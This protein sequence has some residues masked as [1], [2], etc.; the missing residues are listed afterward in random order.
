MGWEQQNASRELT[1]HINSLCST[2]HALAHSLTHLPTDSPTHSPTHSPTYRSQSRPLYQ[3]QIGWLV[4]ASKHKYLYL[5]THTLITFTPLHSYLHK[6]LTLTLTP[7][8]LHSHPRRCTHTYTHTHTNT[9]NIHRWYSFLPPACVTNR[10]SITGNVTEVW[11]HGHVFHLL[12]VSACQNQVICVIV[13]T[14]FCLLMHKYT[15]PVS[16]WSEP[17]CLQPSSPLTH[18][19]THT[20]T[21]A[22]THAYTT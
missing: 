20:H 21:H 14:S 5:H 1:G 3:E 19:H 15:V 7:A 12:R 9:H 22:R 4:H 2:R 10:I 6:P 18:T 11:F 13:K 17:K 8:P 16:T